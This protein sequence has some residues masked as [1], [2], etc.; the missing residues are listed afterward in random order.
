MRL[1]TGRGARAAP[2]SVA[3]R[4]PAARATARGLRVAPLGI[5]RVGRMADATDPEHLLA[6]RALAFMY[7]AGGLL[8][9]LWVVLP[10]DPDAN[11]PG[12]IAVV[13]VSLAAAASTWL[14]QARFGVRAL[15]IVVAASILLVT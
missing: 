8:A 1:V 7:A 11:E 10:H 5:R 4:V 12:L 2:G 14:A 3:N 15:D 13:A 6:A 9:L